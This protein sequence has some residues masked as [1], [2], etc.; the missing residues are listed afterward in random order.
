MTCEIG[1]LVFGIAKDERCH[2][3]VFTGETAECKLAPYAVPVGDGCCIKARA[4]KDRECFDFASLPVD[5]KRRAVRQMREGGFLPIG[6]GG[7]E[8]LKNSR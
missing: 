2:A 3:L 6:R 4:Y 5:F 7:L 8:C 1:Q